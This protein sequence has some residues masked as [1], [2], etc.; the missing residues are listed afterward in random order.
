MV[1]GVITKMMKDF[2]K[3]SVIPFVKSLNVLQC[4]R[5]K[6]THQIFADSDKVNVCVKDSTNQFE[7][8]ILIGSK[9]GICENS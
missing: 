5:K 6:S 7:I 9:D 4:G 1:G 2:V 3:L 8:I